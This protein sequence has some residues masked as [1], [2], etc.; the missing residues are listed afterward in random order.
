MQEAGV[1]PKNME[2]LGEMCNSETSSL[3]LNNH[4]TITF[5][6]QKGL[7]QGGIF[8]PTCCT[9]YLKIYLGNCTRIKIEE[10]YM[11]VTKTGSIIFYKPTI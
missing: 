2:M 11:K 10:Y 9:L 6:I 1:D 4:E 3:I 5:K 8:S 7:R